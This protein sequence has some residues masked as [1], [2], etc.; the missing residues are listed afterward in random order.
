MPMSGTS[1]TVSGG[2]LVPGSYKNTRTMLGWKCTKEIIQY[3]RRKTR[4]TTTF[5]I[6]RVGS[7]PVPQ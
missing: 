7:L 3:L 2:T 6:S 4:I 1:L 5:S